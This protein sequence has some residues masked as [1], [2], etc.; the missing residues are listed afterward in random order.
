MTSGKQIIISLLV[1][2]PSQYLLALDSELEHM[3]Q[4]TVFIAPT[5][6]RWVTGTPEEVQLTSSAHCTT[7]RI[8]H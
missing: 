3:A 5:N 1:D 4:G 6:L 8:Q 2:F 7:E